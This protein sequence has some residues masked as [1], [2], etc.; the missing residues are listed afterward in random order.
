MASQELVARITEALER[1]GADHGIDIVDVEVVG[2]SKA[3]TVRVRIDFTDESL[4]TITLDEVGVQTTWIGEVI[5]LID[6]FPG[7]YTLEVSSPGLSRPLRRPHD[8]ERFAGEQVA[9][10]TN[11]HEGRKRFSG[12]LAG[13]RDGLVV[14]V[15]DEGEHEFDLADIRR[16]TIKPTFDAP[17]KPGKRK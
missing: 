6:P 2:A 17:A 5:D 3:P 4:P 7:A 9:L 13:M 15:D 8:F 12:E 1:V 11:A 14:L 16:C 10:T